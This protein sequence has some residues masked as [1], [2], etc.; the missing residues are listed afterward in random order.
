MSQL[1]A[2]AQ[3]VRVRWDI[4]TGESI[5]MGANEKRCVP[6]FV[7]DGVEIKDEEFFML[8]R[9]DNLVALEIYRGSSAPAELAV[10]NPCGT[11]AAWTGK[12][13]PAFRSK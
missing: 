3:F 6:V 1:Y 12:R 10:P 8:Q 11:I 9:P 7:L 4:A 2:R 5:T 13:V